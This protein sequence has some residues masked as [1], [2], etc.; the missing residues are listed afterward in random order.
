MLLEMG[1]LCLQ[2][3]VRKVN[4]QVEGNYKVYD[5][6]SHLRKSREPTRAQLLFSIL[7]RTPPHSIAMP[8]SA[9]KQYAGDAL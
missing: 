1:V 6:T 2:A 9:V 7:W 4:G 3:W 5:L 8:S